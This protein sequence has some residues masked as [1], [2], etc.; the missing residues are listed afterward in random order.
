M[1]DNPLSEKVFKLLK[2]IPKGKVTTYKE[3]T[4]KAGLKNPRQVGRIIHTNNQPEFYP[5]H[6]VVRSDGTLAEGYK[7][8]G[9]DGQKKRLIG[10]G[11][12][13]S[14]NKINLTQFSYK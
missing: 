3:L 4:K 5:C 2:E 14:G 6:R 9:Q 11:V 12:K 10:E 13:F 1:T 8:G 7:Y